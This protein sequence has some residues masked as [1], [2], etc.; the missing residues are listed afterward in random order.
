MKPIQDILLLIALS[1]FCVT[2]NAA[3]AESIKG[4]IDSVIDGDSITIL[5]KGKEL[6]VRLFGIDTP[7][8]TQAFGQNARNFT[9]AMASGKELRVEPVTK[10]HEG[11]MVAM[12]FVNGV[13]LNEQ[14]VSQGFGWVYRQYCKESVCADWL[15]LESK[16][17]ASHKGLWADENPTPPWDYRQ[18]QRSASISNSLES[19]VLPSPSGK[20]APAGPAAYHGDTKSRIFHSS[21]CKNFTCPTCTANFHSISDALDADYRPHRECIT[22]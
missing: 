15:Q 9:G 20:I 5:S 21:A 4:T 11:R 1:F 14:I 2:N 6:E 22:K 7:E 12:V 13:N 10:D 8:K 17:K 18:K 19:A 3:N 16:A